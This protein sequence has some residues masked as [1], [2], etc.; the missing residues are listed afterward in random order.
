MLVK[1]HKPEPVFEI[2]EILGN[3]GHV[4][5][6]LPPYHCDLNP[7]EMIWGIAKKNVAEHNVSSTNIKSLTEQAFQKISTEQWYNCCQHVIKIEKEYYDR[8]KTLYDNID[9]LIIRVK[10]ESSDSDLDSDQIQ[11]YDD[12]NP[13]DGFLNVEYLDSLSE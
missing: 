3:H 1:Q 12:P 6:R 9:E 4:V 13:S 5:A 8:G 11:D 10:G 2:D 7:I